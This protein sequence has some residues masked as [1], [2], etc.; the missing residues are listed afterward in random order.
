MET[1]LIYIAKDG[2]EFD[3]SEDC[4]DWEKNG[5]GYTMYDSQGEIV[6][7]PSEAFLIHLPND[8]SAYAFV[9]DCRDIGADCE[10]IDGN[11]TGWYYWNGYEYYEANDLAEI[12]KKALLKD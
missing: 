12:F 4:L 8:T 9:K 5:C 6:N 10:G 1:K 2:K 3:S 7:N 11:E